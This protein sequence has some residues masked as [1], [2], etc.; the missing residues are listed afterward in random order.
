MRWPS[1]LSLAGLRGVINPSHSNVRSNVNPNNRASVVNV[2]IELIGCVA[3]LMLLGMVM[4][5]SATIALPDS[6]KY[7]AYKST[8]FLIRHV[9]AMCVGVAVAFVVFQIPTHL[10]QR[11]ALPAFFFGIFLLVIVL[12]PFIGKSVYGA[13]RWIP[14]GITNLQPSEVMK[15]F[16]VLYAA[17]FIVR[18]QSVIHSLKKGFL[19]LASAMTVVGALLLLEP[20]LGAFM[21]MVSI[22]LGLLF[23]GGMNLVWFTGLFGILSVLFGLIIWLSPWRRERMFAYLD[24]FDDQNFIG[25]GYQLA[26]SLMAFGRGEFTGVG[27]GASV[28]KLHYLPEAHTDFLLAIIG[29]EL[30]LVGVI[31]VVFLFFKITKRAFDIGRQ[32]IVV[33]S[34]PFAGLV[35]MGFGLW[36]GVQ[37]FLNMGVNLG[38]LPTKGLTL[39]FMSYGGTAILCNCIAMAV[40]L[41]IDCDNRQFMRGARQ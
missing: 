26:Q 28:G 24:P 41:R 1:T 37:G 15:I 35:A 39:P 4:V 30:G 34:S 17:D 7:S 40:L 8:H 16:V 29:E 3:I 13:R 38:L 31:L 25:K 6:P 36:M 20:D 2:D 14:L 19:P 18:K 33:Q 32:A 21:V 5:Y 27:L 9:F 11:F 23:I 22:A 10:M 12:I